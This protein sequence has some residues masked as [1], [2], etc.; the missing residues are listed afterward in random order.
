[1]TNKHSK[2]KILGFIWVIYGFAAAFIG[3]M[4]IKDKKTQETVW[5]IYAIIGL[6]MVIGS[7]SYYMLKN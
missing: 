7:V 5:K 3:M 6:L 1:M 2:E 4:D